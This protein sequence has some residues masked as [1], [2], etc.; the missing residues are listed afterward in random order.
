MANSFTLPG[1]PSENNIYGRFS[2][3][4]LEYLNFPI[5]M[6]NYQKLTVIQE[7]VQLKE[8]M[9]Q[10]TVSKQAIVAA[11]DSAEKL[12]VD[13]LL[14]QL[15]NRSPLNADYE[16][17]SFVEYKDKK[18]TGRYVY[19]CDVRI[20]KLLMGGTNDYLQCLLSGEDIFFRF[21]PME[22]D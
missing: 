14:C 7:E 9:V 5:K 22:I 4:V 11:F 13:E 6:A 12:V 16:M 17:L 15:L 21:H 10:N 20:G 18:E 1:A 3:P 19:F 2:L 8:I